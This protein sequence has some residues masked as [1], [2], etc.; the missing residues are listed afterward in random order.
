MRLCLDFK[1]AFEPLAS[2]GRYQLQEILKTFRLPV[3][4]KFISSDTAIQD[5]HNNI[6]LPSLGSVLLK[7]LRQETTIIATSRDDDMVRLLMIPTDLDVNVSPANG[8][9]SGDKE[10]ARFCK[11]IHDGTE[12]TKVDL[13]KNDF[14]CFENPTVDVIYDYAEVKPRLPSSLKS[15][16]SEKSDC[17]DD[18]E[19]IEPP[20]RPSKTPPKPK[21]KPKRRPM[22]ASPYQNVQDYDVV[23]PPKETPSNFE[24]A[25]IHLCSNDDSNDVAKV[26]DEGPYLISDFDS[27]EEYI[28]PETEPNHPSDSDIEAQQEKPN[29]GEEYKKIQFKKR[30]SDIFKKALPISSPSAASRPLSHS[31]GASD[32]TRSPHR[33]DLAP[34]PIA[35]TSKSCTSLSA[36]GAV[37]PQAF[38]DD[39]RCLSVQGVGECL[40]MLNMKEHIERFERE[41]IDGE[42]FVTLDEVSFPFLGVNNIFQQRKL[43]KFINGWRPN[44]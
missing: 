37:L 33:Q 8:A 10:Y 39:L 17:S 40:R 19:D 3:R 31:Q 13:F 41:L 42:L 12:L 38:P 36:T 26:D 15:K 24:E 20:S 6:D 30:L 11:D 1:A 25:S 5:A 27:D 16:Q 32:S 29:L 4:V 22:T 35:L 14:N 44:T 28:Y 2:A 18:Y 9:V 43:V 23:K 34:S 21:P 7:E